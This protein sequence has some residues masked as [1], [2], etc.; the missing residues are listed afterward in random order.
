MNI[1]ATA[2]IACLLVALPAA[3]ET[4]DTVIEGGRVMDP[5][6]GLDAVGNVGINAGRIAKVSV[7][8][9]SGMRV[10]DAK[11]L[12]VTAGFIDLHQHAQDNDSS[13]LKAFDGSR[14][15]SRWRSARRTLPPSWRASSPGR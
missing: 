4:Y 3:A 15:V 12:I 1:R 7:D 6:T 13:R 10:L 2:L 11:G 5:E 14:R 8:K 9:L